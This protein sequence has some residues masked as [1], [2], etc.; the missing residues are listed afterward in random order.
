MTDSSDLI[1]AGQRNFRR[2]HEADWNELEELLG[3][4]ERG[5][6]RALSVDEVMRLPVLYRATL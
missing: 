1:A 5:S 6:V 4:A 2:Q 3:R